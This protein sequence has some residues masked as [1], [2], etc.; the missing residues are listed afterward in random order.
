[1]R[2]K[3]KNFLAN[4]FLLVGLAFL[5]EIIVRWLLIIAKFFDL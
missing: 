3:N 4:V 5:L 1:M 2:S